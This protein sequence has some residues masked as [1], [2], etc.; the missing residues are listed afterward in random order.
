MRQQWTNALMIEWA[1][2][3]GRDTAPLQ[4]ALLA[5]PSQLAAF[6]PTFLIDR[7]PF[8]LHPTAGTDRRCVLDV[9]EH[10]LPFTTA[11]F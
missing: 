9:F 10:A 4:T 1:T 8:H 5:M 3:V 7:S 2:P 6:L 11:F